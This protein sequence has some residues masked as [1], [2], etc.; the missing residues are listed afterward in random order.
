MHTDEAWL[1]GLSRTMLAQH[2]PAATESI[3]NL[4]PRAPH[5]IKLLFHF[6]QIIFI[7]SFGYSLFSLRL[8]SLT[9]GAAA[10]F[11][12]GNLLKKLK[13]PALAGTVLLSL[14]IQFIYASRFSR[15][16]IFIL[17]LMLLSL[18]ILYSAKHSGF[19][20][21]LL[22]GLP[23]AI[24]VGFHPN[25]FIAAW[26][27]GLL[28]LIHI[29]RKKRGISEGLG[30]LLAAAAG[31]AFFVGLSYLFNRGFISD[32]G[33]FGTEVGALDPLDVKFLGFDD[34]YHK[35][36]LRVS[37]T[38]YTPNIIPL[39]AVSGLGLAMAAVSAA[40]SRR[41]PPALWAALA[42]IAGV[43]TGIILIGKY[44]APSIVFLVPFLIILICCGIES[45][46]RARRW[47]YAAAA[48]VL[49]I[50]SSLMFAEEIG[51]GRE[52][53]TDYTGKVAA[54]VPP[55]A[56]TLGGLTAGFYFDDRML[57]DWRNLAYL[58]KAGLSIAQYIED[59]GIE[60]IIYTDEIDYIYNS[61]PVWNI[62]YG[63][64]VIYYKQLQQFL[65]ERC[66]LISEFDSPGYGTRLTLQRYRKD[67]KVRVYRL[68]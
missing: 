67:W 43:N 36:F 48:A 57:L 8:L 55:E 61:R 33:S 39:F 18:N 60:Y 14:E 52:T 2:N 42:G 5:A 24:A 22:C 15:Q 27:A 17:M 34:F 3:F 41:L 65:A 38:Y 1:A 46:G 7:K 68:K 26:P 25:A 30:F 51:G 45:A 50:N 63:S 59:I 10:L 29:I 56:R 19:I 11:A 13:L 4:M 47:L 40:A 9:G 66:E 6:L 23:I 44:S 49:L 12:F 31:A 20:L 21:G 28:L 35:L 58:D 62:L 54:A 64:P 53:H 16:E 32:Y 37:G